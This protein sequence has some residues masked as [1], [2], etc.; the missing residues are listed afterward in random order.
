MR[1]KGKVLSVCAILLAGALL[2]APSQVY[3]WEG[4]NRGRQEVRKVYNNR[5]KVYNHHRRGTYVQRPRQAHDEIAVIMPS[6]FFRV[7][8]GN[9]HTARQIHPV[10]VCSK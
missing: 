10:S 1:D 5:N 3:A 4:G 9:P 8:I 6:W 2:I 7:V